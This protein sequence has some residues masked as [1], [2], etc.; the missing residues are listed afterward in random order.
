MKKILAC[1]ILLL[2]SLIAFCAPVGTWKNYLAYHNTTEIEHVGEIY[3]V[4]ASSSLYS[5]N[6]KDGS[7][8]TYDKTN[9]LSDTGIK[10]I[11]WNKSSRKLV[12]VYKNNNIDLLS[13]NGKIENLP[14]YYLKAMTEDKT[15][16]SI[17]NNG[18]FAYLSTAFGILKI[19]TK[20]A[21]FSDTYFLNESVEYAYIA[22]NQLY[23]AIPTK[24]LMACSL[25]S[26]P[27]D[28]SN[29][30]V[31]GAYVALNKQLNASD[32]AMINK[33]KPKGAQYNSFAFMTLKGNTL[34]TV[35]GGFNSVIDASTPGAVQI[36]DGQKWTF[37]E[38][39]LTTKTSNIPY[40]SITSVAIDP[41]DAQHVFASGRTG[42]YEFRDGKFVK[43]YTY[44][45]S[46]LKAALPNN[47]N[48]V[49][50][51]GIAFDIQGN[52]W[53]LN[54][55]NDGNS[56]L[57]MLD[58]KGVW[59]NYHSNELTQKGETLRYLTSPI[60][61][62]RGYLWFV[63]NHWDTPCLVLFTP[64][65]QQIKTFKHITN[66]DGVGFNDIITRCVTTDKQQNIWIGTASGPLL[67]NS[68]SINQSDP[69]F[70]QVKIPR[71]D[72]TNFADYL[73]SGVDITCIAVDGANRKWFGTNGNG[74]YLIS[75][76]N[77]QELKHFTAENSPL[78]SNNIESM[79]I[80]NNTGEVFFGTTEGLCS[81]VTD[82]TDAPSTPSESDVLVYPNPVLP[83]YT[84]LIT[85]KGLAFDSH[86]KIVT[87]NGT[88]VAEGRSNGGT[89]TW[90]GNDQNGQR[91]AGGM[92][93][94][95][96]ATAEGESSVV[97]KIAIIR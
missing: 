14:D 59:T 24:G 95:L 51:S 27:Q 66:Q 94:V 17:Y 43:H 78:L 81:Y 25:A 54:S 76:D 26:N 11:Q 4:L 73:L 90:D 75:A 92:Y 82:A 56:S 13:E 3:Y 86:V 37:Y 28:K 65:T 15:I 52:L 70:I 87:T 72:G 89:F 47:I 38:D 97:T 1:S 45:N 12:I 8:Y 41:K 85:I 46:P 9:G 88:L 39:D 22:N 2:T 36:Y 16:H 68:S 83:D 55:N 30:S 48:Y 23:A 21:E 77:L 35:P 63:N 50:V 40:V 29:W 79:A 6:T 32:L 61:D 34:Y 44:T 57:L 18:V 42:L 53:C 64:S 71:N 10:A 96:S 7:I 67:L 58:R 84:G 49:I 33:V 91:V 93:I 31:V 69:N 80:N 19:N 5:Y 62:T 60:F 74:V 20:N